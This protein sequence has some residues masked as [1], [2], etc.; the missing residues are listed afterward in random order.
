MAIGWVLPEEDSELSIQV[1][2]I[3]KEVLLGGTHK[4]QASVGFQA[5]DS[6]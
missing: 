5:T 1:L 6:A 4:N 3:Y 2:V